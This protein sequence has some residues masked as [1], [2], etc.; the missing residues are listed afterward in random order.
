MSEIL[1][2]GLNAGD[3]DLLALINDEEV[4]EISESEISDDDLLSLLDEAT[5]QHSTNP[6]ELEES[7]ISLSDLL[8]NTYTVSESDTN[9]IEFR[10]DFEDNAIMSLD[11]AESIDEF[12][13]Q[14]A[15]D[16]DPEEDSKKDFELIRVLRDSLQKRGY[17]YT[18]LYDY[19]QLLELATD[20]TQMLA[21]DY[22]KQQIALYVENF[23][24]VRNFIK[25]NKATYVANTASNLRSNNIQINNNLDLD[26]DFIES[27]NEEI[28][29]ALDSID[30]INT[31]KDKLTPNIIY[32]RLYTSL[33]AEMKVHIE[34]PD[35]YTYLQSTIPIF[36]EARQNDYYVYRDE[37][38]R[39][40]KTTNF[41]LH[42]ESKSVEIMLNSECSTIKQVF[43]QGNK[44]K[45]HC[46]KCHNLIEMPNNVVS[47][48]VFASERDNYFP[49]MMPNTIKCSECNCNLLLSAGTYERINS[50]VD[51]GYKDGISKLF[52]FLSKISSGTAITKINPDFDI[53]F[54]S[55]NIIV[56]LGS[57]EDLKVPE[58]E[59]TFENIKYPEGEYSKALEMFYNKLYT[60]GITKIATA[61][62]VV[63]IEELEN[64]ASSF[65]LSSANDIIQNN[66]NIS[67][68]ELAICMS[69][70]LSLNYQ[71]LK[72]RAIFSLIMTI[73]EFECLRE[74]LNRQKFWDNEIALKF[75]S[76][77]DNVCDN[78]KELNATGIALIKYQ[79]NPKD[80]DNLKSEFIQYKDKM[81]R[82]NAEIQENYTRLLEQIKKS[83]DLLAFTKILNIRQINARLLM[84]YLCDSYLTKIFDDVTDKMIINNYAEK[85]SEVFFRISALN[86]KAAFKRTLEKVASGHPVVVSLDKILY[87]EFGYSLSDDM[88]EALSY[89]SAKHL[90]CLR[91]AA[92]NLK[93]YSYYRFIEELNNLNDCATLINPAYNAKLQELKILV[94]AESDILKRGYYEYYLSDFSS[95]EIASLNPSERTLMYSIEFERFVPKRSENETLSDYLKRYEMLYESDLFYTVECYDY[96][97]YFE[98]FKEYFILII[99]SFNVLNLEDN[100][101]IVGNVMRNL[102]YLT[103]SEFS[104]TF[105]LMF[106]GYS[107]EYF[108]RIMHSGAY[109]LYSDVFNQ[110]DALYRVLYGQYVNA[111][112]V[113]ITPYR[114]QYERLVVD[115]LFDISK[116]MMPRVQDIM[117]VANNL[118]D[119]TIIELERTNQTI[120]KTEKSENSVDDVIDDVNA[121]REDIIN[122]LE[123]YLEG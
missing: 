65:D 57:D 87:E 8:D 75:M 46:P 105:G 89:T 47:Y 55:L 63:N 69:T 40:S 31:A 78:S 115:E 110:N 30:D 98:K 101:F 54:N 85:Y 13:P 53:M 3:D 1:T 20:E 74:V 94:E 39:R 45:Y 27:I 99:A 114:T 79:G 44:F 84:F 109:S 35:L 80:I 6:A 25:E 59:E 43:K 123:L 76:Q 7:D 32:N 34:N 88:L 21:K 10:V 52:N 56:E 15:F 117:Q 22:E 103:Y 67:A 83:V 9:A 58:V 36:I 104:R 37:E 112:S 82:Q 17:V 122:E 23:N 66:S 62:D 2:S 118:D 11:M 28:I 29:R 16:E 64:D 92:E 95:E 108:N 120:R 60:F 77:I 33:P 19:E 70:E 61:T 41:L 121:L 81:F 111:G 51:K 106:L 12:T 42:K 97:G 116:I 18:D 100:N 49:Y 38:M 4:E 68:K 93:R 86:K 72:N 14:F 96:K 113:F 50:N 102:L 48:I 90:V 91:D 71:E 107:E 73:D 24:T 119:T 5:P 26:A